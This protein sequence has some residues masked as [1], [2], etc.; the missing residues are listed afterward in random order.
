MYT[1]QQVAQAMVDAN[2]VEW[3]IIDVLCVLDCDLTAEQIDTIMA[4]IKEGA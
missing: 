4:A 3:D 1:L 2:Q